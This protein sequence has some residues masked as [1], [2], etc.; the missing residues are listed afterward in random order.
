MADHAAWEGD[1]ELLHGAAVAMTPSP[2]GPHTERLSRLAAALWNAIDAAGSRATVLAEIDWIVADDTVVR[3]D[4][5]VV[6][7]PAPRQHVEHPPALVV[8]ILSAATRE[9]DLA[10]KR[11]LYETR[12]VGWYL[13]VDPDGAESSLLRLGPNGRYEPLPADGRH[14][15]D[16]CP[17]C[18]VVVD[19]T[20]PTSPPSSTRP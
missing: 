1:W 10:V 9:R 14:E 6:C 18:T 4:L 16:L 3:P 8:E 11:D 17:E 15:I 20:T 5:V 12:G 2:F 7:G 19:L 13:I